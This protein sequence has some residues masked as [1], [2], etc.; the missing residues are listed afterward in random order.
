MSELNTRIIVHNVTTVRLFAPS[1]STHKNN[2]KYMPVASITPSANVYLNYAFDQTLAARRRC[3]PH[4]RWCSCSRRR[5]RRAA[6][7]KNADMACYCGFIET[8]LGFSIDVA[9][10]MQGA[11]VCFPTCLFKLSIALITTTTTKETT[12]R[13]SF[14][15]YF[16]TYL[17]YRH[18]MCSWYIQ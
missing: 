8:Q 5:D 9:V 6:V 17:T 14:Y 16:G 2:K 1:S 12:R 11:P 10:I 3:R 7:N 15:V 4:Q 13:Y 18:Q